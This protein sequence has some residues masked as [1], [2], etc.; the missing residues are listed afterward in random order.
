MQEKRL[1]IAGGS[2]F[3]GRTVARYFV[4][5]GWDVVILSRTAPLVS[6]P[7][8][9]VKWDGLR[10]GDWVQELAGA[11]AIINLAGCTVNCRYTTQNMLD[12][13]TSRLDSTRALGRAIASLDEPPAVWLNS[14]T[15][16]IY[17][18][19]R[20][21][22][23]DEYGDIG[24]GFS[25]DVACRWEAAHLEACLPKTRRV[26][27]RTAMVFGL[28]E[29]GIMETTDQVVRLGLAGP[30]AGGQ[31]YVSWIHAL[32]F[33]RSIEFLIENELNGPVNVSAPQAL[34]NTEFFKV[35]RRAWEV[36]TG[37]P[38]TEAMIR[39]GARMMNTE[40]ELLLKSRWAQPKRLTEAGFTFIFPSWSAA[41]TELV[42]Q[43]RLTGHQNW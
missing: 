18:H 17:R 30:M 6:T 10:Q 25:V 33:C 38:S 14:S 39:L 26:M 20:D 7:G 27:L 8:R 1:V 43:V 24:K 41:I 2:G 31:Q 36:L 4:V 28:G 9:W 29:G 12:I 15:A 11:T 42:E 19:A 22:P 35:Y 23:Q 34:T 32:D 21:C 40:A 16:T 3:L 13:Y 37:L 5:L